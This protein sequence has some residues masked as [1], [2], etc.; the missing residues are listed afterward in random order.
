[1]LTYTHTTIRGLVM[2]EVSKDIPPPRGAGKPGK[3]P[4][5]PVGKMEVGDSFFSVNCD[6]AKTAAHAHGLKNGKKFATR[7]RDGGVRIWRIA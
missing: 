1:M 5:Y 7:K 3:E 2:Y 6:A 4:K